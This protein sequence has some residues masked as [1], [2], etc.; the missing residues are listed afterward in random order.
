M[1]ALNARVRKRTLEPGTPV[2][3]WHPETKG[4]GVVVF[5]VGGV[6]GIR[7]QSGAFMRT[8]A[9]E[10]AGMAEQIHRAVAEGEIVDLLPEKS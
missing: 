8:S 3:W 2:W 6:A 9:E 1:S 5:S 7:F 4:F 10:A